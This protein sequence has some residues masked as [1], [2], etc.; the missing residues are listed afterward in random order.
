VRSGEEVCRDG[1]LLDVA[2]RLKWLL[3]FYGMVSIVSDSIQIHDRCQVC[4]ETH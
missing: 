3:V 2:G 4:T 1:G